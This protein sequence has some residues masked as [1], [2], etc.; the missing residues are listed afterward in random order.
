[1]LTL[2]Q[3]EWMKIRRYKTFWLLVGLF[4]FLFLVWNYG[5]QRSTL[6]LGGGPAN[7]LSSS[8]GFPMVWDTL[9]FT[10]SWFVIFLCVFVIISVSNEFT[11]RTQRQHIID[12]MQRVD[13]LHAKALLILSLSVGVTLF[14]LCA[15]LLFGL[16][17]GGDHPF[18]HA[19]IA[20]SVFTYTLNYLSFSAL[21][22]FVFRR[23]GISLTMLFAYFLLESIVSG[24]INAKFDT[25]YGNLLPLQCSDE[26][27]PLPLLQSMGNIVGGIKPQLSDGVYGITSWVYIGLYYLLL[28]RKMQNT[29]L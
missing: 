16:L 5:A 1:M 22:A 24:I 27:L 26:L 28:R 2:L 4:M 14:Y 8:F 6:S 17:Q 25:A 29:D 15:S 20:I 11:F 23:A 19:T 21:L 10:L 12:G 18:D 13:F 9:G 3:I 7:V